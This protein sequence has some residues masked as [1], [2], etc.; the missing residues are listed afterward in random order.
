MNIIDKRASNPAAALDGTE[1]VYVAQLGADAVTTVSDMQTF[2]TNGFL[3][4]STA[5]STYQTI[6]GMSSY[7]TTAAAASTYQTLSGMSSYLT[8]SAAA[9]TYQTQAGMSSYQTKLGAASSGVDG[10]LAG[11]DWT[12]FNTKQAA[13]ADVV[14]AGVYGSSTQVPVI[15]FNAK[16]IA[17]AI[18]LQTIAVP[19]TFSDAT[20]RVQDNLDATKQLAFEASGIAT[21][22]TRTWTV[23]NA[24]INFGDLPSVA[25]TNNNSVGATGR[26]LNGTDNNA[27]GVYSSV[28][29]GRNNSVTTFESVVIT[30]R[31][32]NIT[33]AAIG[34]VFTGNISTIAA[35]RCTAVKAF[36]SGNTSTSTTVLTAE[37]TSGSQNVA[38]QSIPGY[39]TANSGSRAAVHTLRFLA[40]GSLTT[41]RGFMGERRVTILD[42]AIVDVQTIG[43]DVVLGVFTPVIGFSLAGSDGTYLLAT[44]KEDSNLDT[45]WWVEVESFYNNVS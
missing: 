42:G 43:V 4:I 33:K 9:S 13:L 26:V 14:T 36:L 15:T 29:A 32:V 20:F 40:Q 1:L 11:S 22:A 7:L 8:T 24:N 21:G 27:G 6:A 30:G 31:Y 5:A 38:G 2:I 23:P 35:R 39:L 19:T 45:L 41:T 3:L 25:T 12:T 28:L 37:G 10:Y 44:V 18:T 16:G 34:S 17:T